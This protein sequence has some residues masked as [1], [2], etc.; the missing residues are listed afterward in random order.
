MPPIAQASMPSA[1]KQ[2]TT[3]DPGGWELRHGMLWDTVTYTDNVDT[4]L[5]LF[6]TA[7]ASTDLGNQVSPLQNP[8]KVHRLGLFMKHRVNLADE[9]A[10]GSQTGAFDN[11]VLLINTGW[12]ELNIGAKDYG[13]FPL[14]KLS[15]GAGAYG[16]I[17][18]AGG[19]AVNQAA[20]YANIGVPDPRAAW[21]L[22]IPIVIPAQTKFTCSL[23]W[24]A[25]VDLTGNVA[26]CVY[27]EG[28][29]AR[30]IQ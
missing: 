20:N 24:P 5:L 27:L 19:E 28:I 7:R 25:A 4:K 26:L 17:S 29:E 11:V 22:E 12:L 3:V 18:G 10:A 30:G 14:P 15:S 8:F 9:G 1:W 16:V 13:P 2:W 6:N 23:N 21:E